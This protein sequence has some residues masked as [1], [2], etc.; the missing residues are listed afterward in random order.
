[1]R[2]RIGSRGSDLALW[3]ARFLQSLLADRGFTSE[4][5]VIKTQ[6]DIIQHLSLE[7]LEG[8][9]FFTKEIEDALLAEEID[10]A[11]HSYKDLPTQEVPGLV[12][13]AISEREDPSETLLIHPRAVDP[14]KKLLLKENALV[15]TSSGRRFVQLKHIRPDLQF[16]DIRGNVPTRVNKLRNG[17][18]DAILLATAGLK[19]LGLDTSGLEKIQL[20]VDQ[21]IPAPA[22]GALAFQCRKEDVAMFAL[23]RT[24]QDDA[25]ASAT[26]VE[27]EL[28]ALFKGGCQLPLGAHCFATGNAFAVYVAVAADRDQMMHRVYVGSHTTDDL[29]KKA[30]AACTEKKSGSVFITADISGAR[31]DALRSTGMQVSGRSLLSFTALPF[32]QPAG[33]DWYFFTSKN[34]VH[35]FMLGNGSIPKGV[36]VAA[37]GEE[38]AYALKTQ[39][40]QVDYIGDERIAETFSGIAAGSKVCIFGALHHADGLLQALSSDMQIMHI[41]VYANTIDK[42]VRI[43][44]AAIYACTSPMQAEAICTHIDPQKK[45][46]V[47]IGES[48]ASYLRTL[49][50]ER[51]HIAPKRNLQSIVDVLYSL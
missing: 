11:V 34:G 10:V 39:G 16:K 29:A 22:Q 42:E 7:K 12:I 21:L 47:A 46:F 50:I 43:P 13:A 32:D 41:P 24:V 33:A 17:D 4:I 5:T 1:M 37:I 8:K 44:E 40:V 49:G 30:F 14:A 19:R 6:G 38:T 2:I 35:F 3:Q 23:L 27:R 28:L 45:I 25:T 9:G 36:R 15:G 31:F 20:P 48:T 51:I 26:S 18:F